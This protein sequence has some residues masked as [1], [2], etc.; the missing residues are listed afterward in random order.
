MAMPFCKVVLVEERALWEDVPLGGTSQLLTW[1]HYA[2]AT[3]GQSNWLCKWIYGS[4]SEI[5]IWNYHPINDDSQLE[6][7]AK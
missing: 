7:N 6:M 5:C 1:A 3:H 4:S 2:W